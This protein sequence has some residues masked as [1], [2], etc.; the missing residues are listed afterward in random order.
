LI[1]AMPADG[2]RCGC[3]RCAVRTSACWV[4][5]RRVPVAFEVARALDV[6]VVRKLG[7]PHQPE[8]AF[9]AI[10]EDGVRVINDLVVHD[11][12]LSAGEMSRVEHHEREELD[13]GVDRFRAGRPRIPLAGR[14]AVI[15]DDGAATGATARAACE[16]TVSRCGPFIGVVPTEDR[17]LHP[18]LSP[19]S[20][21]AAILH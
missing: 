4:C 12:Q 11:A 3:S 15:V 13:R 7:V 18:L 21:S 19:G 16:R 20:F 1:V 9:G 6:I 5:P 8:L 17:T 10:G 14:T 2:W